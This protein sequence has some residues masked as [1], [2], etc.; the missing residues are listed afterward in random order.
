MLIQSCS[1]AEAFDARAYGESWAE[2]YD[3][4][5]LHPT[6]EDAEPAADLISSIAPGGSALEFGIGTGRIAI[7]LS[8]RGLTVWG[9]EVSPAMLDRLADK[10]GGGAVHAV[11]GD[12]SSC[13]VGTT[14]DVVYAAFNTVLMLPTQDEQVRCF[15]NAALHLWTGGCFVVEAFVPDFAKLTRRRAID[16]RQLDDA[17]AWLVS[18]HHDPL[19]QL[20]FNETIRVDASGPHRYPITLRYAWPQ[21]LD[22]MARLAGFTLRERWA[23]WRRAPFGESSRNQVSIYELS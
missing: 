20:I 6:A 19:R 15:R 18:M 17:G 14:F 7:P 23:D 3:S 1:E 5:P 2:I 8:A 13:R 10:P 4:Y 16:V 21:E 11:I 22:L 12:I 9:V